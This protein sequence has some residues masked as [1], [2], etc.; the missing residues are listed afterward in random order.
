MT[1]RGGHQVAPFWCNLNLFNRFK[2]PIRLSLFLL[3]IGLA[4]V[5]RIRAVNLLPGDYDEDD[6]LRAAQQ[7]AGFIR[8]GDWGGFTQTNYRQE[9]PALAKIIFGFSI[10][11][12][13][14]SPLL[15]DRGTDAPPDLSL[16]VEQ[17]HDAR[18][19]GAIIGTLTVAL[20]T[21]LNPV[22]GF[23]LAVHA[24]TIKYNSQV[25]LEALPA[26]TSFA[27]VMAYAQY[28]K[29]KHKIGWLIV[30]SGLLGL[31]AASKYIY[32]V[33]GLAV[34]LDWYIDSKKNNTL[35][36]FF[37]SA[38]LWGLFGL[39]I[40]LAVNPYLWPAPI[41]RL[42]A[43]ILYHAG[44]ASGANEVSDANFPVWQPLVWLN[45]SPYWWQEERVFLLGIDPLITLFATF[46]LARLWQKNRVFVLWLGLGLL[47]LLLWPTKW[48]QYIL[49]LTAPLAFSAAEGVMAL[50]VQPLQAWILKKRAREIITNSNMRNDLHR[51]LPWL[52]P[53][54]L[55]FAVF[56]L[57]PLVFQLGVSLTDFNSVSIKDGLNGGIWR[58]VS[59]GLTGKIPATEPD[60]PYREKIVRYTGPSSY[61]PVFD[62]ISAEGILVFNILW[63]LIS[64]ALQ[65]AL[66]L[67][68]ALILWQRG[69]K[70][71]RGWEMLF[72]LPW[73]IPEMIGALMWV[74]IFAPTTGWLSLAA[75]TYGK[76]IPFAF[77]LGWEQSPNA[78]MGV[79]LIAA[80]WYGFPFMMLAASAGLKLVHQ[81]VLDAAHLDGANAWQ[82]FRHV[83]WPLL[84]PLILPAIIIRG[85]FAFNQFYL[86]QAFQT[87]SG[88]L[89]SFS[90]NLFNPSGGFINGQFA[91]SA[92]LNIITMLILVGFVILFNRWSKAGEGVT[93][94]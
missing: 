34:L 40:F 21:L 80:I 18:T 83:I 11:R 57:F 32:C 89:A 26:L 56:T 36:V 91:V 17:L 35:G 77:L 73:A 42:K 87:G 39:A 52:I 49:I 46:G 25:M 3:V 78:T 6:Y 29:Q 60:F 82:T 61:L 67:G 75:Q 94:A 5:L 7:Y 76:N 66:G 68:I 72:I 47:F 33:A 19:S 85:V 71:K 69:L 48:P 28:R 63:A 92:V 22:G 90:Y 12:A 55:A 13:P 2:L 23:F 54:L 59:G 8:T 44:S 4:W 16:P 51:A 65:T 38:I 81:E 9:H 27:M 41:E 1:V 93:Y 74:N 14:E 10:L 86:F 43:S 62:L 79:L 31:T 37:R 20:L 15:P 53:G 70:F 58:E 50:V 84:M 45:T 30:S 88:T 64:V 24:M